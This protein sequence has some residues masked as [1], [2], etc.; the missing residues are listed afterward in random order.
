M[1]LRRT[2][3]ATP[4]LPK[5]KRSQVTTPAPAA[6]DEVPV[7]K[8]RGKGAKGASST[9]KGARSK[10]ED[11]MEDAEEGDGGEG[12]S[13]SRKTTTTDSSLPNERFDEAA[14]K[15]NMARAVS[16]CRETV[17]HMVGSH[18]RADPSLLDGIRVSFT[19]TRQA[20]ATAGD[21]T[22]GAKVEGDGQEY[23]LRDFATVGVR[24]G[25]L[26]VTCFDAEVRR[27]LA[28]QYLLY[29]LTDDGPSS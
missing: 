5:S 19:G 23:S 15:A 6:P 18:G 12:S 24:D 14:L 26:I 28:A 4:A 3:H 20:D 16:R 22:S 27:G 13:S 7:I 1:P 8:T 11:K 25:A 2:L 9:P 21:A 29:T 10:R 17:A